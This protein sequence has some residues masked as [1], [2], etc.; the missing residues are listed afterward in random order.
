LWERSFGATICSSL[1]RARLE[2][3]QVAGLNAVAG[4]LQA[5]GDDVNVPLRIPALAAVLGG[6]EQPV[7]LE[8]SHEGGRRPGPLAQR[9]EVELLLGLAETHPLTRLASRR[10]EL[11]T[12]NAQRQ[13]L[14][15]LQPE[16][17]LQPVDVVLG[18]EPVAALRPPRREQALILEVADL[19]DRNVG[20][21]VL[22]APADRADGEGPLARPV[23]LDSGDDGG[24]S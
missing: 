16:D 2:R 23:G 21:L 13:E 18:E 22:E 4:E 11:L 10:R 3:A 24:H 15:A 5:R 9:V 7:V 12:N 1:L 8:V 19:R 17:G 20:E 6:R 14:V